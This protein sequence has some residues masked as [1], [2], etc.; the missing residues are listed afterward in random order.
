MLFI[1][2]GVAAWKRA[3]EIGPGSGKYTEMVLAHSQARICAYDV[4]NR[5]LQ[6]CADRMRE[7]MNQDRLSLNLLPC[8]SAEEML[9]DLRARGWERT[10]DAFYSI[11]AMV[12]VDLQYLTV[13][14]I[15]AALVLKPGG[16]LILSLADA[17][18][19]L[20]FQQLLADSW[21]AYAAQASQV[22]SGKFEWLSP[23]LVRSLLPR[24]G[25]ELE[26]LHNAERDL[27]VV[28]ALTSPARSDQLG[29][30]LKGSTT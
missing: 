25:F 5:F 20:G 28:A 3:V 16:K 14:L 7:R 26:F 15:T 30:F 19:E 9:F 23:E 2:A 21:W 29:G 4:S 11:D 13:Y 12:H 27:F 1:P 6:I 18:T 8:S 10:V 17:T 24:L 22:G